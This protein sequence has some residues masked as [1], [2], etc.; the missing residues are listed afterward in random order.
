MNLL[1]FLGILFSIFSC[2]YSTTSEDYFAA[3]IYRINEFVDTYYPQSK[4]DRL[5]KFLKEKANLIELLNAK[6]GDPKGFKAVID[7]V[8]KLLCLNGPECMAN[9][10]AENLAL[11]LLPKVTRSTFSVKTLG[12]KVDEFGKTGDFN[13][14][15]F[16]LK[17]Y[18]QGILD[19]LE[20]YSKVLGEAKDNK[21]MFDRLHIRLQFNELIPLMSAALLEFDGNNLPKGFYEK[22][23]TAIK[24]TDENKEK[25]KEETKEEIA[26]DENKEKEKTKDDGKVSTNNQ[27]E[28]KQSEKGQNDTKKSP[29]SLEMKIFLAIVALFFIVVVIGLIIY[30]VKRR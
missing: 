8:N 16:N 9:F 12:D 15:E 13:N 17:D 20:S 3:Y 25:K 29:M 1:I 24:G 11:Y 30:F 23:E 2:I 27:D 26:K 18:I 28:G 21:D 14:T 5:Y 19:V 6:T 22:L 10:N 4:N 7:K